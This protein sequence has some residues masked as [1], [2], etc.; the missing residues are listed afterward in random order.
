MKKLLV[1]LLHRWKWLLWVLL[2]LVSLGVF[3]GFRHGDRRMI[4]PLT[5]QTAAQRW[6]TEE[7]PYAE[8]FCRRI[9][10]SPHLPFPPCG[11]RWKMR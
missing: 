7:K 11:S 4:A 1:W 9:T 3:L 10:P 8:F 2:V 5:D 6:E